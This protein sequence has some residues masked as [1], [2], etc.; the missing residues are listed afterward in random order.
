MVADMKSALAERLNLALDRAGFVKGRGRRMDLARAMNVS[1]EA[2]RKWLAGETNPGL[3]NLTALAKLTS[4][5]VSYLLTGTPEPSEIP[6]VLVVPLVSGA[7][8]AAWLEAIHDR[9]PALNWI[10]CPITAGPNSCALRV[11]GDAMT[12]PH[13]RSY[14]D[15]AII[16]VDP[17]EAGSARNG[18][19][20]VARIEDSDQLTFRA[21]I[22]D[23]PNRYLRALNP[24]YL[25][26]TLDVEVLGKVVGMW[27]EG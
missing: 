18:D 23:G 11:E 7:S 25:P 21:L 26:I 6:H 17:D 12:A 24:A 15:G 2:A 8:A 13:G 27:V 5:S 20:V 16:F 1:G 4:V 14:P 10:P 19:R 22:V 9:P 3:E